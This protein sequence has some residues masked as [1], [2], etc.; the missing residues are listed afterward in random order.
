MDVRT[1][2]EK[3]RSIRS[4]TD[5]KLSR[6]QIDRLLAAAHLAPSARNRQEWRFIAVTDSTLIAK[7]AQLSE[8]EFMAEAPL[9]IVGVGLEPERVMRCGIPPYIVDV[10]IALTQVSLLAVEMG[11]GTCWIGGYPQE[12]IRQLLGVPDK[13][14]IVMLMT[15]GYP[16]EEPAPKPRLPFAEVVSYDNL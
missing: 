15:V 6:E 12:E 1:A 16:A 9:V 4:Y 2:I 10:T 13:H 11:L 5:Q 8:Q 14:T 7:L 3:R